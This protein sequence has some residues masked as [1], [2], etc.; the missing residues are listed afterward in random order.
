MLY[1]EEPPE[2]RKKPMRPGRGMIEVT[3]KGMG[4]RPAESGFEGSDPTGGKL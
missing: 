3:G 4:R 1:P 2:V